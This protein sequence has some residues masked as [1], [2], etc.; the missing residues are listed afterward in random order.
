MLIPNRWGIA[1][2]FMLAGCGLN[3]AQTQSINPLIQKALTQH[4]DILAAQAQKESLLKI[5]DQSQ[6]GSNPELGLDLGRKND[7]SISGW[8]F[9]STLKQTLIYP[10]KL[11][12]KKSV[13]WHEV[14]LQDIE[15]QRLKVD[16]SNTLLLK[17]FQWNDS[18][19]RVAG[20]QKRIQKLSWIKAYLSSRP[21]VSPQKK[22][23]LRLIESHLKTY[24]MENLQLAALVKSNRLA[25]N[26]LVSGSI[27]L[28]VETPE[29][30]PNTSQLA[31]LKA[32]ISTLNLDI[33]ALKFKLA[34]NNLETQQ[35]DL[36]A[37]PNID[38]FG[39]YTSE[40]ASGTDQFFSLGLGFE[41]PV[42]NKNKY[43]LQAQEYK[44]KAIDLQLT[45]LIK[46][47][48]AQWQEACVDLTRAQDIL[49][50]YSPT[51]IADLESSLDL[52]IDGFKKG[53][54]DL[55]SILELESQWVSAQNTRYDAQIAWITAYTTLRQLV[56]Q[57]NFSG[58]FL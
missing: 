10:G 49:A 1:L 41:L 45:Q 3:M 14:L 43:L 18:L 34:Q 40:S 38:V 44:K 25:L 26:K 17:I 35:L 13:V 46:E 16:L 47:K 48:D 15:I 22:L 29:I 27:T 32:D 31:L 50:L 42:S 19:K 52:A 54:T 6:V 56:G 57:S 4:P 37:K 12:A 21:F 55:L 53:Q 24:Q 39:R 30:P 36:D 7:G 58:D 20:N 5:L 28:S 51:W 2:L 23:E 8:T 11:E 9:E 33:Q